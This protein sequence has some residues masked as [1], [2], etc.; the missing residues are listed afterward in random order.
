MFEIPKW[1]DFPVSYSFEAVVGLPV[2]KALPSAL[3][4]SPSWKVGATNFTPSLSLLKAITVLSPPPSRLKNTRCFSLSEVIEDYMLMFFSPFHK[5]GIP[6][7][8]DLVSYQVGKVSLKCNLLSVVFLFEMC[9]ISLL[10]INKCVSN[11]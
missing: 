7:V 4:Y 1:Q 5:A 9:V 2:Y 11:N 8:M 10:C 6:K 3:Q